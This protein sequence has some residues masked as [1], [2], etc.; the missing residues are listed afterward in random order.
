MKVF[1]LLGSLAVYIAE[2]AGLRVE[3]PFIE[4][5][6]AWASTPDVRF[7]THEHHRHFKQ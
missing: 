1:Q 4:V 5:T 3:T 2:E 6:P 7:G